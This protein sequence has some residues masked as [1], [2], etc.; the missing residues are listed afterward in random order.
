MNSIKLAPNWSLQ[1]TKCILV[2]CLLFLTQSIFSISIKT[3]FLFLLPMFLVITLLNILHLRFLNCY[4]A[5]IN[6]TRFLNECYINSEEIKCVS[7]KPLFICTV[8]RVELENGK[9]V[10]FYNW[11]LTEQTQA[12]I[13]KLYKSKICDKANFSNNSQCNA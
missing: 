7:F 8:F 2:L 1:F 9:F 5:G 13:A 12:D 10:N 11:R 3:A 4:K 6:Y